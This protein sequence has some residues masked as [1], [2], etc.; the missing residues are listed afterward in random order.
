MESE[1]EKVEPFNYIAVAYAIGIAYSWYLSHPY[2]LRL[3][4]VLH[5]CGVNILGNGSWDMDIVVAGA[6]LH[7][8]D[9]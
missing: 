3:A 7:A 2:V 9:V 5:G 6:A 4:E 1:E 8:G